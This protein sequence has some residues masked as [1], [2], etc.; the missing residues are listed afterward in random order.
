MQKKILVVD[1]EAEVREYLKGVLAQKGYDVSEASGGGK[2]LT[3]L[4]EENFDLLLLD[5]IMPGMDGLELLKVI[6]LSKKLLPVIILTA[7]GSDKRL[8]EAISLGVANFVGKGEGIAELINK[9]EGSF[10][11]SSGKEKE[12]IDI[13]LVEDEPAVSEYFDEILKKEGY[14]VKAVVRGEEAISIVIKNK[15][16]LILLDIMLPGID[17]IETLRQ[18]RKFD[19]KVIVIVVSAHLDTISEVDRYT[20]DIYAEL[21]KPLGAD[22]L[23]RYVR[24]A[25][26]SLESNEK[27]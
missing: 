19:Q 20:L 4:N 6:R 8:K 15:P 22:G 1:D 10:N 11:V 16:R 12:K 2:A 13:L 21:E 17:G 18:I 7:Y 3:K 23:K 14:I 9:I 25:L 26:E 27:Q 24:Q 5:L